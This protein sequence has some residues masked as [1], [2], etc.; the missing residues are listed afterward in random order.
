MFHGHSDTEVM[1]AA[2][3]E[4]GVAPSVP[5][6]NGMFAFAVWDRHLRCLHLFRDRFGEKPLYYGT[7][8]K[9]L[10]FASELKA[11]HAHPAFRPKINP[12]AIPLYL[13]RSCVPAPFT[14]YEGIFKLLPGCGIEIRL[15]GQI[16]AQKP[17]WSVEQA[18]QAGRTEPFQGSETEALDQ[19]E[20]LLRDSV[21]LRMIADVP[22]GAFLSGGVDSS[23]IVALMLA[24][25]ARRI[26]TFT[27]GFAESDFDEAKYGAAVA[28]HLGTDH[29]ELYV[30]A[31]QAMALV[32]SL[33]K[34]YDEPFADSSQ[35]PTHLVSA[36]ARRSVTVSLSGDGADEIFGGYIQHSV[37]ANAWTATRRYP[38][39]VRKP[40]AWAMRRLD[41]QQWNR[42]CGVLR[43]LL[44]APLAR[45]RVP[46]EKIHQLANVIAA[47]DAGAC[48]MILT[49]YCDSPSEFVLNATEP[50][51][52]LPDANA[53]YD[54]DATRLMMLLDLTTFLPDDILTKV[55]RASMGTSLES[56]AP[57][58]D[59][60]LFEFT[61]RLPA[62]QFV[63]NWQRKWALRQLLYRRVPQELVDRPKRGFSIP[64]ASWLRGPLRPWAE[65]L[66]SDGTLKATGYWNTRAVRRLWTEHLA[67][68]G[69][70]RHL[71]WAVLMFQAWLSEWGTGHRKPTLTI[72][73]AV[74]IGMD[75]RTPATRFI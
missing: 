9:T 17:Y 46:G 44:P 71:L 4:W 61:T 21:K 60:R 40:T 33:P 51:T 72:G 15:G 54:G 56:R 2:F 66:L 7:I 19:L 68:A 3:E 34:L 75:A 39:V 41:P 32:P 74:E 23:M 50:A 14:I 65:D 8:G 37:W 20:C 29:S 10:F 5:R 70:C 69:H 42:L 1:L 47:N 63:R 22:V 31:A 43:P 12:N 67:G 24:E 59:H 58:L 36:L 28:Q 6:F 49:S 52:R 16:D 38:R 11:L 27:I 18:V 62:G 13:R 53:C 57:Y 55:D 26:K 45:V 25:S 64:L 73:P 48:Y 30:S 35:I